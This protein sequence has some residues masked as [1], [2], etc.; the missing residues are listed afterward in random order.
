MIKVCLDIKDSLK[1]INHNFFNISSI[2]IHLINQEELFQKFCLPPAY[3]SGFAQR[4][5]FEFQKVIKL[6]GSL[7]HF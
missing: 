7:R 3:N 2:S 5:A 1:S 4:G 6:L